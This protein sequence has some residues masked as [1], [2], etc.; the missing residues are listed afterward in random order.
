MAGANPTLP[1]GTAL[2]RAA[3][4]VE[5]NRAG[6]VSATDITAAKDNKDQMRIAARAISDLNTI[7]GSDNRAQ[8]AET[9]TRVLEALRASPGYRDIIADFVRKKMVDPSMS[10][11]EHSGMVTGRMLG[12][13]PALESIAPIAPQF[14]QSVTAAVTTPVP[15][16]NLSELGILPT[17]TDLAEDYNRAKSVLDYIRNSAQTGGPQENK[18]NPAQMSEVIG[19]W[20]RAGYGSYATIMDE[21]R[22]N[23]A[24]GGDPVAAQSR[25]LV[26]LNTA[27]TGEYERRQ[28]VDVQGDVERARQRALQH[29]NV[30]YAQIR[31][32]IPEI[33]AQQGAGQGGG[34]TMDS[35]RQT[36][37][38]GVRTTVGILLDP[39]N[40]L[41]PDQ[42]RTEI[43]RTVERI[44]D[45]ITSGGRAL[46]PAQ[47]EAVMTGAREAIADLVRRS[48]GLTPE[49]RRQE[50]EQLTNSVVQRVQGYMPATAPGASASNITEAQKDS[51]MQGV[52]ATINRIADGFNTLTPQRQREIEQTIN[53]RIEQAVNAEAVKRLGGT[54]QRVQ[55]A[56][57]GAQNEADAR[58]QAF[59]ERVRAMPPE[60]REKLCENSGSNP[61]VQQ[62]CKP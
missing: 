43:A 60:Q 17:G 18:L 30:D 7:I 45:I 50:I 62:A 11:N 16:K 46:S 12:M 21:Q 10:N 39:A 29:L 42:R 51:I 35:Q 32:R 6:A 20:R 3:F 61:L 31:Q 1:G 9:Q 4:L 5:V 44:P 27:Y 34:S 36:L 14:R 8:S 2:D 56:Q 23:S 48:S 26:A 38:Q 19:A 54:D 53:I 52:Q 15:P 40:R 55:E 22:R 37:L 24:S 49:Q 25:S 47:K 59:I 58:T 33:L 28:T 41:T 13:R 57:Q